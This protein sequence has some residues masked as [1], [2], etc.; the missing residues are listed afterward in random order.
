MINYK[1]ASELKEAGFSQEL[2]NGDWAYCKDCGESS[3]IHLMHEDNDEGCFVGNDYL[4]RFKDY[5]QGNFIKCPSLLELIYALGD[6]FEGLR[7]EVDEDYSTDEIWSCNIFVD[8]KKSNGI[9]NFGE[10]PEEA[11]TKSWLSLPKKI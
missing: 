6:K 10:S 1:L 8:N 5:P 9:A 7:M 2:K 4:H 3:E 11:V